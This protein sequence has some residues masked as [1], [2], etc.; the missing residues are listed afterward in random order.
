MRNRL[1]YSPDNTFLGWGDPPERRE[2]GRAR[3][4]W[5]NPIT[6][7]IRGGRAHMGEQKPG[8]KMGETK[9]RRSNRRW[10]S[11]PK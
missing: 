8:G 1:S 7:R 2:G 11:N 5:V 10:V 6:G 3:E 9:G 4:K